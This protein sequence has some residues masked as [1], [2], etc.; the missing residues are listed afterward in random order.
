[1]KLTHTLDEAILRL[2]AGEPLE[3]VLSS[4]P[5]QGARLRA[6]LETALRLR[7]LRPVRPTESFR[8]EAKQRLLA[9]L[10]ERREAHPR[11]G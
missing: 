3:Q 2:E 7:S 10:A 6:L 1:M 5:G 11:S 4:Y 9:R 8:Q